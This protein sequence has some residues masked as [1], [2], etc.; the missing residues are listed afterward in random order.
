MHS[1]IS[2]ALT[3]FPLVW[4]QPIEAPSSPMSL[5]ISISVDSL[6][7]VQRILNGA[8]AAY[9]EVDDYTSHFLKQERIRKR[10]RKPE[11]IYLKF[12]KPYSVYL[13]WVDSP[14]KGMEVIYKDGENQDR[15]RAH[16]G[17]FLNAVVPSV[18]LDIHD[19]VVTKN[20]R[21]LITETGIGDFLKKY[22]FDFD[23]ARKKGDIGV[24]V[25]EGE[26]V[27]GRKVTRVEAFLPKGPDNGYYCYRSV[28]FF[29]EENRLPIQMEF[30]DHK[31]ELIEKYGYEGLVLNVGLQ[32]IDFDEKNETYQ[33]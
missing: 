33:F 7:R 19:K 25:R 20:N 17:G 2:F 8:H 16:L 18:N 24:A 21:H 28:I 14:D 12:Q 15:I 13:K 9:D 11:K 10:L 23:Q 1:F 4:A 22:Q 27:L 31:N 32:S 29:D 26:K 3:F 5:P 30:Y 6:E